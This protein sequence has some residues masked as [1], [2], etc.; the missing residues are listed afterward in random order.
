MKSKHQT[1]LGMNQLHIAIAL[2]LIFILLLSPLYK[3]E[4]SAFF[5]PFSTPLDLYVS[6]LFTLKYYSSSP[7]CRI[8]NYT[9]RNTKEN[10]SPKDVAIIPAV[11]LTQNIEVFSRTLRTTGSKCSLV[12]LL[13]N[14]TYFSLD[15]EAKEELEACG[16]QII[17]CGSTVLLTRIDA[18]DYCYAFTALFI[19]AN[20]HLIDRAIRFDMYDTVLQG[21]PF[22]YQVDSKLNL[23]DEGVPLRIRLGDINGEW[24]SHFDKDVMKWNGK[25][26]KC[27]G[28]IG[29]SAETMYKAFGL[30]LEYM[31]LGTGQNDQGAVNFF[32]LS[33]LYKKRGIEVVGQRK[34]ELVRHC[35][36]ARLREHDKIGDIRQIRDDNSFAAV[37]H[38]YY[39]NPNLQMSILRACPRK[40]KKTNFYISHCPEFVVK[41][42]ETFLEN[43]TANCTFDGFAEAVTA[44]RKKKLS[45]EE[46]R[47][48]ELFKN[49]E[50]EIKHNANKASVIGRPISQEI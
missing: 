37:V 3:I 27:A 13:D 5:S 18:F 29:G 40:H 31:Q 49:R 11:G 16:A 33:G 39:M 4:S 44:S 34:N 28:Y 30:F 38:H 50:D 20:R 15:N 8:C 26:Y 2:I 1:R 9:V 41:S 47:R 45:E 48:K 43:C 23:I 35:A 7:N 17:N 22:N 14:N 6:P 25:I 32:Y 21:D 46:K 42:M 36:F 10:S 24:I 12:I 19:E